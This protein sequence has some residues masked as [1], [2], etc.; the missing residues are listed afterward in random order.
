EKEL[1]LICQ[2]HSVANIGVG[3]LKLSSIFDYRVVQG[4]TSQLLIKIPKNLSITRVVNNNIRDWQLV[5]KGDE[6]FIEVNL[7]KAVSGNI[8]LLLE[9]ESA[10]EEF[11]AKAKLVIP[12]PQNVIR[13]SGFM[14]VGT[15]SAI[16]L[17]IDKTEGVTQVESVSFQEKYR[18]LFSSFP[19]RSLFVY[20]FASL[21]VSLDLSADK[22]QPVIYA[23]NQLIYHIRETEMQ[24]KSRL[25]LEVRDSTIREIELQM[26]KEFNVSDVRA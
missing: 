18:K 13:A 16:K 1:S 26:S 20:N 23:D 22:V 6:N 15:D 10:I 24:L 4:T 5:K 7:K 19:Q 8:G 17:L 2:V 9:G 3:N 12:E 14:A 21:P 25:E 11:P